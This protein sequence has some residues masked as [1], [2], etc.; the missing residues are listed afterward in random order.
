MGRGG[1]CGGLLRK[2]VYVSEVLFF[3]VGLATVN[4][5]HLGWKVFFQPFC[6]L[7]SEAGQA[8]G[9]RCRQISASVSSFVC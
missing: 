8:T 3:P 4:T 1:V 9:R 5:D 6:D 7:L 2:Q